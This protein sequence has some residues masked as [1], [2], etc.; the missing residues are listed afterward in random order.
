MN[1]VFIFWHHVGREHGL[2]KYTDDLRKNT[3]EIIKQSL[4][5]G[6]EKAKQSSSQRYLKIND[7][8]LLEL[9]SNDAKEEFLICYLI[10]EGLQFSLNFKKNHQG[11]LIDIVDIEEIAPGQ[12]CVHDLFID[13]LVDVS[14]SY[15]IVD[16]DDFT[17]AI[18]LEILDK[19]Q[20]VNVLRS[21]DYIVKKINSGQFPLDLLGA[22]LKE[23]A[24]TLQR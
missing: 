6:M 17:Q 20:I 23:Y 24:P 13:I 8:T 12:F 9:A 15:Q 7:N 10:S 4:A 5:I 18:E 21:L 11:W 19:E 2:G 16:V 1:D 22:L 3:P 14:G